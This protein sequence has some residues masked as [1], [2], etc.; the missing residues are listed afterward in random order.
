MGYR[1][2]GCIGGRGEG[3][4]SREFCLHGEEGLDQARLRISN[5]G[6][7]H[8][9]LF[10]VSLPLDACGEP[11]QYFFALF[12]LPPPRPPLPLPGARRNQGWQGQDVRRPAGS[13]QGE[14]EQ[15][16]AGRGREGSLKPSLASPCMHIPSWAGGRAPA[17][18][19]SPGCIRYTRKILLSSCTGQHTSITPTHFTLLLSS[20]AGQ[21]T[22]ITHT[23][24]C[25][26]RAQASI[27]VLLNGRGRSSELALTGA[28]AVVFIVGVNGAGKTTTIG[29]LAAKFGGEGAK[30]CVIGF[31][32]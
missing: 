12:T 32:V 24:F 6:S 13:A 7:H 30:V 18:V 21:H 1:G 9:Q 2:G 26:P 22:S 14:G 10:T 3:R 8:L 27:I 20:C 17:E 11:L 23:H 28:P 25:S 16:R 15:R 19:I 5:I 29:K 4:P 31:R